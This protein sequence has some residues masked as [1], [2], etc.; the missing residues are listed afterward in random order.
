MFVVPTTP[1]SLKRASLLIGLAKNKLKEDFITTQSIPKSRVDEVWFDTDRENADPDC[2]ISRE[3]FRSASIDISDFVKGLKGGFQ[4]IMTMIAQVYLTTV[5]FQNWRAA[6]VTDYSSTDVPEFR[7]GEHALLFH[8]LCDLRV[9]MGIFFDSSDFCDIGSWYWQSASNS[10]ILGMSLLNILSLVCHYV[11]NGGSDKWSRPNSIGMELNERIKSLQSE[12][13]WIGRQWI[14]PPRSH[15]YRSNMPNSSN[16]RR[17]HRLTQN[18]VEMA[19][20]ATSTTSMI[21]P[22]PLERVP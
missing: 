16:A 14:S 22:K 5:A 20:S 21:M 7:P 18:D 15:Q 1:K 10:R 12:R 3:T 17:T 19:L 6:E 8:F 13:D 9:Q 11:A 4:K 2:D